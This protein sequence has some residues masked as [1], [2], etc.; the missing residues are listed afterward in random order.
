MTIEYPAGYWKDYELIDSGRGEK[1]ERFGK[2]VLRR[3]EPK[4]LWAPSLPE[5]EWKRLSH[6][7]FRPGAG[8]GKAGKEDSGTWEKVRKMEDQW[9]IAYN[10]EQDPETHAASDLHIALRLG[11]TSFKHVGVFPEQAPNWE[12]I[13]RETLRLGRIAKANG[14]PAP[15]VL[16]LF[17]Y[18]GAASLAAKAAGADVTHLDSVR[19][20]VTW[21]RENM[22]RSGLDGVRWVVEDALK[23]AKR[24]AKRGNRY[25]GII[26][27]PPAYGHGPDGEKWKLDE[28]LFD[29]LKNVSQ[30]LTPRDSFMVLNLYSN[31][32]SAMLGE[33]TV[34]EAFGLKPEAGFTAAP[35]HDGAYLALES[36]E[37]ALRDSFGKVLPLSIFVRLKR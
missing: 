19:Q 9:S 6:V 1:L 12:F 18:T 27:D 17:A 11:L 36:G 22:E 23:F 3:P 31:G 7:V 10:G 26:L 24:E 30:I 4:A 8:F 35:G 13:F 14:L 15:K 16:N 32:Y 33:T 28:L 37:L 25:Q 2:Y 5:N 34:R 20:V 29:L 21:A